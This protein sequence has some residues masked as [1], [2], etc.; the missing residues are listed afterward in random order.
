MSDAAIVPIMSQQFPLYASS[1]VK[2]VTSSGGS[3]PTALFNPN[4]GDADIT[5]L[6]LSG[7]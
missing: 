1:R 3:Y 7:S 4:I 2:G 6:W 5:N